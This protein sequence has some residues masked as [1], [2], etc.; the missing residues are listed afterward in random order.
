M[1]R[2]LGRGTNSSPWM[3]CGRASLKFPHLFGLLDVYY[4]VDSFEIWSQYSVQSKN[5]IM[6]YA[7]LFYS[8]SMIVWY[9]DLWIKWDYSNIYFFCL[10]ISQIR[11]NSKLKK[12]KIIDETNIT[13]NGKII[14][15]KA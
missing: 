5:T 14:V 2:P 11:N 7:V 15:F 1:S 10:L 13:I 12:K 8:K 4:E 3:F 9:N 6:Y